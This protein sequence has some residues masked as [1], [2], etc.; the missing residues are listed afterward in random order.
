MQGTTTT[1]AKPT[2][3]TPER[4]RVCVR[5]RV[6]LTSTWL[7]ATVACWVVHG[8]CHSNVEHHHASPHSSVAAAAAA[9]AAD[10]ADADV[11]S[12]RHIKHTLTGSTT[13]ATEWSVKK[14]EH[15]DIIS[16]TVVLHLKVNDVVTRVLLKQ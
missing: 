1:P 7:E 15:V 8:Q 14:V 13:S 2:T 3:R 9:A 5:V 4:V 10:D 6:R 16:S 11:M 12:L